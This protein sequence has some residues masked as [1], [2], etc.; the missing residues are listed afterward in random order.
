MFSERSWRHLRIVAPYSPVSNLSSKPSILIRNT[1]TLSSM[2]LSWIFEKKVKFSSFPY[3][4]N[5]VK[6]TKIILSITFIYLL[7][8]EPIIRVDCAW[9]LRTLNWPRFPS[10]TQVQHQSWPRNAVFPSQSNTFDTSETFSTRDLAC[11]LVNHLPIYPNRCIQFIILLL[12]SLYT[13]KSSPKFA[14]TLIE[15]FFSRKI[16]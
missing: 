6:R 16:I 4:D 12:Y 2:N 13:H 10:F 5:K 1:N 11:H 14:I 9:T 15:L 3:I 7:T 8:F